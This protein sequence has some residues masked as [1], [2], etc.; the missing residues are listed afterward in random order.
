MNNFF[1]SIICILFITYLCKGIINNYPSNNKIF[2]KYKGSYC[3]Y[4]ENIIENNKFE[5]SSDSCDKVAHENELILHVVLSFLFKGK[6][7]WLS[8]NDGRIRTQ[9]GLCLKT[10]KNILV[11]STCSPNQDEKSEIWKID[12]EQQLKNESNKCAQV[13][14]NKL[15]SFTCNSLSSTGFEII[16]ST[17]DELNLMKIR[18]AQKKL[19]NVNTEYLE[20]LHKKSNILISSYNQLEKEIDYILKT[21]KE[22]K[23]EKE[24][25]INLMNDVKSIVNTASSLKDYGTGALM[26]IYDSIDV[27]YKK[28][29]L[30]VPLEKLQVNEEILSELGIEKG[31][32]K[33]II[34]SFLNVSDS[35]N[36]I[37]VAKNI[38]G[39]LIVKLDNKEI[40]ANI[41][42]QTNTTISSPLVFLPK[43]KIVPIYIEISSSKEGKNYYKPS[44]TLYWSS[45]NLP[46]QIINSLYLYTTTYEKVCYTP[47]QKKIYCSETFEALPKKNQEFQFL[48]PSGCFDRGEYPK[49]KEKKNMTTETA[50]E[51][52][53]VQT[54][55]V[56]TAEA[57]K[58]DAEKEEMERTNAGINC[59]ELKSSMCASAVKAN[60]LPME[61]EGIIKVM[62]KSVRNKEGK[63]EHCGVLIPT[64]IH[65][66]TFK[67]ITDI[68]LVDMD[69][70]FLNFDKNREL[71]KGY[72]GI[73]TDDRHSLLTKTDLSK[74]YISDVDINCNNNL[75]DNYEFGSGSFVVKRIKSSELINSEKSIVVD[76]FSLFEKYSSDENKLPIYIPGWTKKT[77]NNIQLYIKYGKPNDIMK[78]PSRLLS[79]DDTFENINFNEDEMIVGRCL[80]S[81]I[82]DKEVYGSFIYAPISPICKSA[83]HSGIITNKG[84]L[85]EIRK[86]KNITQSFNSTISITR[87]NIKA[88]ITDMKNKDS[89][90]ITKPN[91]VI[92]NFPTTSYNTNESLNSDNYNQGDDLFPSFI[93]LNSYILDNPPVTLVHEK[94]AVLQ[95]Q[96][97]NMHNIYNTKNYKEKMFANRKQKQ[98]VGQITSNTFEDQTLKSEFFTFKENYEKE[99]EHFQNL[100]KKHQSIFS[101]LF[102]KKKFINGFNKT[103]AGVRS[104]QIDYQSFLKKE[105]SIIASL[106]K[107]FHIITNKKKFLIERLEK[108]LANVKAVTVQTFT[109]KYNSTNINDNYIVT[110]S[111]N[112]IYS[113]NWTSKWNIEKYTN[114][115][116]FSSIT[117][118]SLISSNEDLYGSYI[119]YRYTKLY[120]GFISL[121]V[122]LPYEGDVGIIF[123]Y[124]D[125]NNYSNF[126][127]N[128]NEFY[129]IQVLDG[130]IGKKVNSKVIHNSSYQLANWTKIFIE[131][132]YKNI[133]AYINGKYALGYELK[134]D[135]LGLLG[136]GVNKCKEKVFI[137]KIVI[138]SLDQAKYYKIGNYKEISTNSQYNTEKE[139]KALEMDIEKSGKSENNERRKIER[140][141]IDEPNQ[142]VCRE[143]EEEFNVPLDTNWI[144][145]SNSFWKIHGGFNLSSIWGANNGKS[146]ENS[147]NGEGNL[148]IPS[149]I[150][151]KKQN[152]CADMKS[153]TFQSS[154]N[155]KK[156]SK[157]GIIFRVIRTDDFL[158][159]ILDTTEMTGKLYLLKITKGIP[160]QLNTPTHIPINPNTWYNLKVSYNGSSVSITLNDE[161]ILNSTFN[162]HLND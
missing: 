82:N 74:R 161:M 151:L 148:V 115:N 44:F 113:S 103:L 123:K 67:G 46:E 29:L 87:N 73:V 157:C 155:L 80:P 11:V 53:K 117:N 102:M 104:E 12:K 58:T 150:L 66:N 64:N 136:F 8:F 36:Y 86:L 55:E 4:P 96:L 51:N 23:I 59:Y 100:A 24:K 156:L 22:M 85:I 110:D 37:F 77:C 13:A 120:K 135:T 99:K 121:D 111:N 15:F 94:H 68:K 19:Q 62:V 122:K 130:K 109:E 114:G 143:F 91:G 33:I 116:L 97:L 95:N 45:K 160:Y 17:P 108:S 131:F 52:A 72:K 50:A 60:F 54:T 25:I 118:D 27:N 124:K 70:F 90:Y 75:K 138:G 56:D 71:Y 129:F 41:D 3:L 127:I 147:E 9:N 79:C 119:L 61:S 43:N 162:E 31:E 5:I 149:I 14:G 78:Y 158:S 144:V 89:Y 65:D 133:R 152:I 153:F 20:K 141:N 40:I 81:C 83:I 28:S 34:Q 30:R 145:P 139:K 16:P 39:N 107:Q 1:F 7:T 57:E 105:E 140:K 98:E 6:I 132:G 18:Y 106:V 146:T 2:L 137:D 21:D 142:K 42:K 63:Y 92:C 10:Y 154:I 126:I 101:N 134:N 26:K 76:M 84:G 88:T 32:I 93:Q 69:D 35:N 128:K 112:A 125:Y 49:H 47:L 48:C 38:T 159:V